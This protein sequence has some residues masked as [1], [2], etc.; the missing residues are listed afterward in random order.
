MGKLV[1]IP[2]KSLARGYLRATHVWLRVEAIELIVEAEDE[3]GWYEENGIR[4][5]I[6]IRE[7]I[8]DCP[9]TIEEL[10][11]FIACQ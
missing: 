11:N 10:I 3:D 5:R 1:R 8:I 2:V 4:T 9:L 7:N 6:W